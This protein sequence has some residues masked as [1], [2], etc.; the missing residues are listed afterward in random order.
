MEDKDVINT[1]IYQATF[2]DTQLQFAEKPFNSEPATV[3]QSIIY[4]PSPK[5]IK[6]LRIA[7]IAYCVLLFVNCL[8]L[9]ENS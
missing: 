4:L 6:C 3:E 2:V 9:I 7:I 8:I 5:P 1:P